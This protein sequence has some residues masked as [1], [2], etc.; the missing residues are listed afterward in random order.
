MIQLEKLEQAW[1]GLVY[2][3]ESEFVF[4]RIDEVTIP[5]I[6]IGL[7]SKF[8]R[9]MLLELPE[10]HKVDFQT[11]IKKNLTL[12]FFVDTGYIVLEL[13][14]SNY[15]DL[16][17]DLIISIYNYIYLLEDVDEYSKIFIQMFYKWSEFFDDNK[18]DKLSLESIEGIFGELIVLKNLIEESDS[19]M[20]NDILNSWRGLYDEAHDFVLEEKNI[21]V[22]TKNLS[23][24]SVKISSEYQLEEELDK[25]LEL[26]VLSVEIDF[27]EGDSLK[28]L[29]EKIKELVIYKMADFSIILTA[30]AQKNISPSNIFQYDNY[31]FLVQEQIVYDCKQ[32]AFPRLTKAN[33]SKAISNIKYKLKLSYLADYV[34]SKKRFYD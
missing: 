26:L 6:N 34:I 23:H 27:I 33:T 28:S 25:G 17:N 11:M 30:L 3:G 9:C 19:F 15:F 14:D 18:S 7:N 4:K 13:T 8:N 1:E 24:L 5:E 10:Q 31:R 29:L 20:L 32:N 12:S 22:K 2:T 16:F 21:E